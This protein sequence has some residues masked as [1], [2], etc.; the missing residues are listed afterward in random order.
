[1]FKHLLI[2][3]IDQRNLFSLRNYGKLDGRL[4]ALDDCILSVRVY[5]PKTLTIH[6]GKMLTKA[7]HDIALK[8]QHAIEVRSGSKVHNKWGGT[9]MAHHEICVFDPIRVVPY[10]ICKIK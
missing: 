5:A 2:K 4:N 9:P 3:K 1:M 7:T 10:F 6:P 8:K